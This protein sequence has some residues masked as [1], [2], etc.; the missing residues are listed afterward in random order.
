MKLLNTKTIAALL[1]TGAMSVGT[2]SAMT[3][4]S[5]TTQLN[6]I[7]GVSSA[8]IRVNVKDGVATL[9]GNVDS[10]SEAA[11]AAN[12]VAMQDGI[13]KVRNLISIN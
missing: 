9:F 3:L 2:A 7:A 10:G 8:N 1:I 11:L 13:S 4:D 6:S 12:H 5:G